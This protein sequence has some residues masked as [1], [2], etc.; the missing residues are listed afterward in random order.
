M[1]S[2]E[3]DLI[4]DATQDH[5]E[6]DILI[7]YDAVAVHTLETKGGELRRPPLR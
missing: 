6:Q 3:Q 1:T 5:H 7:E 2:W 4:V